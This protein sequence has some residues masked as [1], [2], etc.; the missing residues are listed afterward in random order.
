M[1]ELMKNTDRN[2]LAVY[3]V[4]SNF[5]SFFSPLEFEMCVLENGIC[6]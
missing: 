5:F 1:N 3:R 2:N 6:Y 4:Y